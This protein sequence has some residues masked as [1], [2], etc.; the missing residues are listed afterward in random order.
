MFRKIGFTAAPFL[1]ASVVKVDEGKEV[2]KVVTKHRP[3]DLPLYTP[4][5]PEEKKCH[6]GPTKKSAL[7]EGIS[8]VRVVTQEAYDSVLSQTKQIDDFIATGKEHTRFAF[9]YLNEP[10]NSLPRAG[11]IA[12]GAASGFVIGLRH[13]FIRRLLYTSIGGGALASI[14]YPKEAEIY[15]QKGL[16]EAKT[17]TTIGINF[18]YGVKPGEEAQLPKIPSNFSELMSSVSGL[19]GSSSDDKKSSK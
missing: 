13:G 16:A 5:Y 9:D 14:C 2:E 12:L 1:A 11:A 10:E 18:I 4:L 15:A 19:F 8:A 3:S 17:W 6:P 7:E